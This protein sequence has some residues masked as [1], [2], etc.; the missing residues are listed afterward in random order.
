MPNTRLAILLTGIGGDLLARSKSTRVSRFGSNYY[1]TTSTR[2][3]TRS[4]YSISGQTC[5]HL[6]GATA[7]SWRT[8]SSISKSTVTYIVKA[9]TT[10]A[11]FFP[12]TRL[13][14]LTTGNYCGNGWYCYTWTILAIIS[15]CSQ[16]ATLPT[17]RNTISCN[18]CTCCAICLGNTIGSP[19]LSLYC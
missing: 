2:T 17:S 3:C 16:Y 11:S 4:C 19:A 12:N 18:S 15:S 1:C 7:R 5:C 9:S 10:S 13:A 8:R 6:S 14:R